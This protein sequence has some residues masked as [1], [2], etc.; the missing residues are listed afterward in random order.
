MVTYN[1]RQFLKAGGAALG[2][3]A[4]GG[5]PLACSQKESAQWD[6]FRYSMCNE[7]LQDR[8]W[9]EQCDVIGRNGYSG[10]EIAAF[11]LVD[12]GVQEISPSERQQMVRDAS[13]AG[14]EVVGLHWLL[15]PPPEGL[16]FTTPDKAVR[17]RSIA[18]LDQLIDF[19]GD[20]GGK[21]MVF[22]SP[23]QRSTTG[24]ATVQEAKQYFANGLAQVADHAQQR[25]VKILLESLSKDQTDVVNT[26]AEAMEIVNQVDHPAIQTMFDFH[27]TA[28]ET[29]P[30]DVLVKK[31]FDHIYHVHVQEMDGEYLGTG[32][33]VHNYVKTFQ[34]LKN[35]GYNHWVSL[36]VF[37]FSP[38][39]ETIAGESMKTLK[40]IE[41]QVV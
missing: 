18:Y 16:H 9:A 4:L 6:G 5:L 33:A 24:G 7:S 22:G 1:R 34:T 41:A 20:L 25:D 36:E 29:E 32:D 19:C 23:N 14:L 21:V 12:K 13:N 11:T 35:L 8:S 17:Q 31:Y 30:H 40:Q 26:L 38:G 37:D 3:A 27:N 10:V 2:L 39:G 28:N 15:S